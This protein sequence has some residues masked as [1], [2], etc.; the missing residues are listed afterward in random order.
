MALSYKYFAFISYKREDEK[1][2]KWLQN[3]LETYRFPS[4]L[5][6][7]Y[8]KQLPSNLRPIFRDKTD[9]SKTGDLKLILHEELVD[10]KYLIV[11][12][13]PKS[14]RSEWV[15]QEILEF[16]KLGREENIIPFII[17]GAPNSP[18]P[19]VQ[20]YPPTISENI[21]GISVK[22]VGKEKAVI[23]VIAAMLEIS[24]DILW[25]RHRERVFKQRLKIISSV[26]VAIILFSAIL[27]RQ[28]LKIVEQNVKI[29]AQSE[30]LHLTNE[31]LKEKNDELEEKNRV[32][33]ENNKKIVFANQ[34]LSEQIVETNRQKNRALVG[35]SE[36]L[37]D[38][39][40]QQLKANNAM[41]ALMLAL[42]ALPQNLNHPNRPYVPE[43][44]GALRNVNFYLDSKEPKAR[45]TLLDDGVNSASFNPD[46]TKVVTASDDGIV[47]LWDAESGEKLI[48]CL[49]YKV[50]ACKV[51]FSPDGKKVAAASKDSTVRVWNVSD[52]KVESICIGHKDEVLSVMFSPD[53]KKI[54]TASK[55]STVKIWDVQ[56]GRIQ[57][58]YTRHTKQV[59]TAVFSSGGKS[60]LS[61]SDDY[62]ARLWSVEDGK[63]ITVYSGHLGSI[64]DLAL[65]LDGNFLATASAD[66]TVRIWDIKNTKC[67][68]CSGHEKIVNMV[69]FSS[70]GKQVVTASDDGSVGV[71]DAGNGN[72]KL[73]FSHISGFEIKSAMFNK[74]GTKILSASAGSAELHDSST[75]ERLEYGLYGGSFAIYSSD[76]KR[77][78]T[79]DDEARIWD[80]EERNDIIV[81]S[82]HTGTIERI[83]L[84]SD[85]KQMLTMSKDTTVRIWNTETGKLFSTCVGHTGKINTAVF[86]PKGQY[87]LTASDDH[88]IRQWKID[89][90]KKCN[91]IKFG[92][93]VKANIFSQDGQYM[94]VATMS[95]IQFWNMRDNL[96]L[97]NKKIEGGIS[98]VVFS[99]DGK[100]IALDLYNKNVLVLNGEN[101]KELFTFTGH[102]GY[103]TSVV[104]SPDSKRVLTTSHDHTARVWDM[105]TG[106]QI[107]CMEHADYVTSAA[108]SPNGKLIITGSG[109]RDG[110]A[111]IWDA[112]T[113]KE[114]SVCAKARNSVQS[115]S[116]SP[117]G[118]VALIG[119][120][121]SNLY[122]FDVVN[123]R[124][125]C[126]YTL[127][128]SIL[129]A[130]F[131]PDGSRIILNVA[132]WKEDHIRIFNY[133]PLQKLINKSRAYLKG[134]K[135][136]K[137]ERR[138]FY[139]E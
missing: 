42:D 53:S 57:V 110:T 41:L 100:N 108:Y 51:V 126:R 22:E 39:S 120:Y 66:N 124:E 132:P 135:F 32:I 60:V 6:K 2:A 17:D 1:W 19:T 127:S 128:G 121:D 13:S 30:S 134:R 104:F 78:L 106:K 107:L 58:D 64:V 125:I 54:V 50:Q 79:S 80:L 87:I 84:S 76:G 96:N 16:Q 11:I 10:S 63:D 117:D 85:R 43:A 18:D 138:K 4:L 49:G 36:Y 55:D 61:A 56:S 69:R 74:D 28:N 14:A 47:R 109:L 31:Q 98:S 112:K 15:N 35:Q 123:K 115:V 101:G 23:K 95:E 90:G 5:R 139:L 86:A 20:C 113:G 3:K 7:E 70:D 116:F 44:E 48:D 26:V 9:I 102:T 97:W 119:S 94:L 27:V 136:T 40:R 33:E 103:L 118:K 122:I 88:T 72:R 38:L 105:K 37:A 8:D 92:E 29:Q 67:V 111:K 131:T 25:N 93:V 24:F 129:Y 137:E 59:N 91:V 82:G 68:V 46:G 89:D 45:A 52:G 34:Q 114:V 12:C 83:V 99:P 65:S 77:V 81:C 71:W 133:P 75:G 130:A 62:T 73:S 21:L